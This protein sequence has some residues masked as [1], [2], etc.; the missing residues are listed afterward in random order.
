L[1]KPYGDAFERTRL[2]YS[3]SY[4][5]IWLLLQLSSW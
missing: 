4:P 1:H 5:Y 2:T 3:Y